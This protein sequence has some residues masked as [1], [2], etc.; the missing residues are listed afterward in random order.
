MSASQEPEQTYLQ[1]TF[2]EELLP[3][4]PQDPPAPLSQQLLPLPFFEDHFGSW[5][6]VEVLC[7]AIELQSG[8]KMRPREVEP[9]NA[10]SGPDPKLEYW[11][12][13]SQ[14]GDRIPGESLPRGLGQWVRECQGLAEG[15][16][17]PH[18]GQPRAFRFQPFTA[19][20]TSQSVVEEYQCLPI[21]QHQRAVH[22]GAIKI[23]HRQSINLNPLT[24]P[25]DA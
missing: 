11:L 22:N 24:G 10:P 5:L 25:D 18:T 13:E 15:S 16:D 17:S 7:P 23:C 8:S 12:R 14:F 9:V 4:N 6:V 21:A 2:V 1:A 20:A 3:I 19:A